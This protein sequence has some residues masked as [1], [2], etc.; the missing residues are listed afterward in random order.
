MEMTSIP[1]KIGHANAIG[2]DKENDTRTYIKRARLSQT[3]TVMALA[4]WPNGWA[5]QL[6]FF[7][8]RFFFTLRICC[9]PSIGDGCGPKLNM[10]VI[11]SWPSLN[12]RPEIRI[13]IKKVW[14]RRS[15]GVFFSIS[16]NLR[17]LWLAALSLMYQWTSPILRGTWL[18]YR[19]RLLPLFPRPESASSLLL[20]ASY[21][22]NRSTWN[23]WT[24]LYI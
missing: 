1:S 3:W 18:G 7:W 19:S 23:H 12:I 20:P 11:S 17:V 24:S 14:P 10:S 4:S 21:N 15:T 6:S 22:S 5:Y 2:V 16:S 13:A 8:L 9:V